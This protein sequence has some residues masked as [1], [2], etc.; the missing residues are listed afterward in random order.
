MPFPLDRRFKSYADRITIKELPS[1][2]ALEQAK[3]RML[4]ILDKKNVDTVKA[5]VAVEKTLIAAANHHLAQS[6]Y[7]IRRLARR[8][9][10]TD[11]EE[12][13]SI[14]EELNEA[15]CAL[16][17]GSKGQLNLCLA[18]GHGGDF[19]DTETFHGLIHAIIE[20]APKLSPRVHAERIAAVVKPRIKY[21][22]TTPRCS[23]L[24]ESMPAETRNKIEQKAQT[25]SRLSGIDLLRVITKH[26]VE[27]RPALPVG[28]S[29]SLQLNFVRATNV[30][31]HS[32]GL[33]GRLRYDV[34]NDRHAVSP[35]QRFCD[36][37]L[38]G[39]GDDSV[40]SKRQISNMRRRGDVGEGGIKPFKNHAK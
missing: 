12:L 20:N 35:F 26:L 9:A 2:L 3:V 21:L 25:S 5:V 27:L 15:I 38:Y 17:P 32:L 29:V 6:R 39:V 13:T 23:R 31:W 28:R 33:K 30:V 16:P 22:E 40:I 11:L 37:A 36:E 34:R 1:T 10:L 4:A 24:W 14:L 8:S 18:K 7:E 19:F